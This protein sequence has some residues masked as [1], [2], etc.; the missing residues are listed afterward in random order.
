MKRFALI[1]WLAPPLSSCSSTPPHPPY[2]PQATTALT[3]VDFGPPP[4]RVELIPPKPP[5]ADAWVDGEWVRRHGRWYWL[6]G[7]WVKTP[8][9]VTYSPWV[10]VRSEDGTPFYAPS[11]WKNAKGEVVP[12]PQAL[13]IAHASGEAIVDANND[14]E[15]TGR[16]LNALPASRSFPPSAKSEAATGDT[17]EEPA[18]GRAGE[19]GEGDAGPDAD[20]GGPPRRPMRLPRPMRPEH[21]VFRPKGM[22]ARL[23]PRRD[24]VNQAQA[25]HSRMATTMRVFALLGLVSM[26]TPSCAHAQTRPHHHVDDAA[27]AFPTAVFPLALSPDRRYVV[28]AR[29]A[30]FLI[31]GDSAW[32][33]MAKLRREDVDAYLEDRRRR[34][35]NAILVSLIEHKFAEHPPLNAYGEPPFTTP[36]DFRAPNEAYF[37]NVDWV[38]RRAADKGIAVFLTV[39]YLGQNGGDEGFYQEMVVAGP[40]ALRSY[41]AFVGR[42]YAAADNVVWVLGGDYTPPPVGMALVRALGEGL[43]AGPRKHLVTAHWSGESSSQDVGD[44]TPRAWLDLDATYTYRPVYERSLVDDHRPG[45]LPHFLVETTYEHEHDSTPHLLRAQAYYA[46]LSGAA[47]QFFG[48]GAIWGFWSWKREL[49]S[50]GATGMTH[51][52]RLLEDHAW[53]D[54]VPDDRHEV[55]TG[56]LGERGT[57]DWAVLARARD[58]S[59][60]LAYVPSPRPVTIDLARL[61]PGV[62]PRWYD[63]TSGVYAPPAGAPIVPARGPI[64][65]TPPGKNAAGDG[66]WVLVLER[67]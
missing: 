42:R 60:A 57:N 63:P 35:F 21:A 3:S 12:A 30:P 14:V 52:R 36:G 55:L 19:P 2:S 48:N 66:D 40:D 49:G 10:L 25:C 6:V 9:K 54:L 45:A 44:P 50:P 15:S 41:G 7:R 58:A 29:G 24:C 31:Q 53:T 65:L 8:P 28:D 47:G 46:L 20:A 43:L 22:P 1:L 37:E 27:A 62:E 67:P 33:I 32:A 17:S 38:I 56:G 39:A 16:N 61:T 5:S 23:D 13:A 4:G 59:L 34:G 11:V 64:T 18:S 26:V 51:A